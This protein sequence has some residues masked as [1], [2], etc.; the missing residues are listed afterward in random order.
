MNDDAPWTL[1]DEATMLVFR[2]LEEE[3]RETHGILFAAEYL[4]EFEAE[5]RGIAMRFVDG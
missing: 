3:L 2:T 1:L 5:L 4:D